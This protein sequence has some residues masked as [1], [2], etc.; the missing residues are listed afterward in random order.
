MSPS[1][2]AHSAGGKTMAVRQRN[3]AMKLYYE[4]PNYCLNCTA[5]IQVKENQKVSE[6]RNKKFCNQTCAAK[7]NNSQ[8]K[9]SK[10]TAIKPIRVDKIPSRT[11]GEMFAVRKNWQSASMGL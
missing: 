7:H 6:V 11:K 5:V 9:C 1:P 2:A 8:R 3:A 10:S 4:N